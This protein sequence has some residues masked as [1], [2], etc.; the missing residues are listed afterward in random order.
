MVLAPSLVHSAEDC[1]VEQYAEVPVTMNGTRPVV[2]GSVN[3]APAHFVVD[4]GTFY[5]VLSR[6]SAEKFRLKLVQMP[7]G[8]INLGIGGMEQERATTAHDF[9]LTGLGAGVIHG[10]D[11]IVTSGSIDAGIDGYLGQAM[12]GSDDTEYDLANGVIRLFRVR[13]CHDVMLAY[14]R[15]SE[16]VGA[17][18]ID[19]MTPYSHSLIGKV[20]LNGLPINVMIDSG[21]THSVLS[22]KAAVR[23]GFKPEDPAAISGG[24]VRGFGPRMRDSWLARFDLLDLGGEQIKHSLLRV[25]DFDFWGHIDLVLGSDFLLSHRLF[26]ANSQHRIYFTYNGG[27]VFDLSIDRSS[28]TSTTAGSEEPTDAAGF[29]RRAAASSARGDLRSALADFDEAVKRDSSDAENYYQRGLARWK[30]NQR[31][32]ALEDF[33]RAL[34]INP[35]YVEA[36]TA[37]GGLHLQDKDKKAADADFAAALAKSP[38]D[39]MLAL[40]IAQTYGSYGFGSDAL[41][42]YD[43]WIA[44]HPKDERMGV[45]LNGRCWARALMG[46]ELNLALADC[47][48]AVKRLSRTSTVLDSRGLVELRLGDLDHA[49]EDYDAAIALQ[50][51]SAWSL[52]GLGLAESRKGHPEKGNEHM[53]AALAANPQIA[54]EFKKIGLTPE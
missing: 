42:R 20:M 44:A 5:G 41:D 23:A 9:S 13:G 54:D 18:D 27:H 1:K 52:Y 29:R 10:V 25:I 12:F 45:A 38:T 36:M 47:N 7:V 51:D 26:V 16:S 30:D 40:G 4:T 15:K 35:G 48:S 8:M 34:E 19:S 28:P 2:A 17:M 46:K 53:H 6:G 11:F 24:G 33:N 39:S 49:I 37:R 50:P 22:L 32:P 31:D 21:S 43:A 3:G 14:W